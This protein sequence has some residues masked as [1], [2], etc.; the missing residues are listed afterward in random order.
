V[1]YTDNFN[2]AGDYSIENNV[3]ANGKTL[4]LRRQFFSVA[5]RAGLAGQQ[6][7]RLVDFVDKTVRIRH[8]VISDVTPNLD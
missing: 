3:P 6:L 1:Q 8:A 4:N 7:N 2:R 5:P